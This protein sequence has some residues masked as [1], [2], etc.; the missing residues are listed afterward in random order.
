LTGTFTALPTPFTEDGER[1][2][3]ERLHRQIDTQVDAGVTGVVPCGT[4]GEAA[5][6]SDREHRQVIADTIDRA[7]HHGMTVIAGAG[8]NCTQRAVDLHTFAHA[9]GADASLQVTPYY[10]RPTEEGLVRH[11]LTIADSC[12]LPVVL[13]DVPSR[14]GVE[15]TESV[16]RRLAGHP[17]IV[18]IKDAAGNLD[19]T[20]RILAENDIHVLAGDDVLTLPMIAV[21]ASGV[22]SVLSNLFPFD[23]VTLVHAALT[24]HLED[25]RELHVDLLP[26]ARS[27]LTLGPNPVPLKAALELYQRDTGVVRLPLTPLDDPARKELTRLLETD[28][29]AAPTVQVLAGARQRSVTPGTR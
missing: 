7:R 4:T 2:D 14:T 19:R 22:V 6:L 26:L 10:N 25:A 29:H 21:G 23:V 20:A 13:Y 3:V 11:F 12:D 1:I 16:V 28:A 5:T 24:G 9:A 17:N 18:G 27:L 15:L 8:S